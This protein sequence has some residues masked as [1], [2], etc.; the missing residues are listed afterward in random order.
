MMGRSNESSHFRPGDWVEV[1]SWP[2]ILATLDVQGRLENL[3]FMPEMVQYCG[4]RFRVFRRAEKVYLDKYNVVKRLR[5]SVFLEGV[6][7]N[8]QA[9]E[10]CQMECRLFWKEAW[11]K[12]ISASDVPNAVSETGDLTNF[13]N[14]AAAEVADSIAP[15]IPVVPVEQLLS[16]SLP[17]N[18]S[19]LEN[20]QRSSETTELCSEAGTLA[21]A[22][23]IDPVIAS[24]LPTKQGDRI[25]C[26]AIELIDSTS[27]LPWW[28]LRQYLRD[29]SARKMSL[30]EWL[31]MLA[32]LARSKICRAFGINPHDVLSG[33]LEK[34]EN[35]TQ[36]LQSGDL[37]QVKS[38]EAI[39]AT[40]DTFGRT[41][42][43]GFAPEMVAFCGKRFRV[44]RRVD[45]VIVEYSAEMRQIT[46]TVILEGVTCN[47]MIRRCCPRDCYCL[48]REVWLE[49]VA[50]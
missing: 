4:R 32:H 5:K 24:R 37:V 25:S 39:E 2:E 13:S 6:R 19:R 27:P 36:R 8:G 20:Q 46:N 50:S 44:L 33:C 22:T 26:Q 12:R 15:T 42:G 28:K 16:P 48:W 30:G 23:S 14:A 29:Y 17:M 49:R 11:L 34:T 45:R 38:R 9:H 47:G 21:M 40:L 7:C 18:V 1:R 3:P 43:L 31:V 10:Q 41:R 35:P